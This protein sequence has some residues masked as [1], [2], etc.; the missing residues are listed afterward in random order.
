MK[1]Y[2]I[3]DTLEAFLKAD[4]DLYFFGMTTN[5]NINK[6]VNQEQIRAGIGNNVVAIMSTENEMDFSITVG[7]HYHEIY[8]IQSGQKFQDAVIDATIQ[9]VTVDEATGEVTATETTVT[10][11]VLDFKADSFPK[12][13]FVQLKTIVYDPDTNEVVADL[14]F[15]FDKALPDGAL[16]EAFEASNKTS[17]I[18]FMAQVDGAGNYSKVIVVPRDQPVT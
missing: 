13:Y 11:D 17:E 4:T 16:S 5:G 7:L 1:S 10:G 9:D 18:N 3:H 8:E 15:I 2:L 6:A 14:Y 12:N